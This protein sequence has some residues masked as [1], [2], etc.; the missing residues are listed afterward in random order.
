MRTMLL[1]SWFLL[2]LI[3]QTQAL[4]PDFGPWVRPTHGEPWPYPEHRRVNKAYYLL[5]ASTFQFNV[6][7]ETCDIVTDAVERYQAIILKEAKIAK[8]H[9]QGNGKSSS[10]NDTS[11][12]TLTAL[13]IHLGEPCEKDGNHWPHLQMSE[14]YVLSINEMSTAAKLV[15][16]SVWGILRGLETFSQLI[17][18]AGDGSNLKIKCQTIHDSPKLRHRG[19]LLDTSR[20]YLPISDILL[21]LD[22]MSYNKLNVLHW[23]IV[24]DNS[25]PYQSSKYPNLSAKG[26]YHPSMVYTLNDIQKIVDY[27]RLR[28]IRVMPEFD[29][30]GHTRSWGLAYPELLT[31]CYDAEG[32]TTGKLGPMN[33]INPNVYEFLR[34]L[35]AEI[36]QVF[37][38]QYVH[39]GGDEVPFSCWMSNPEIN[40]YMKHR[41]MSKN[42]ALL[43]GEYIAKLLQITDSLEANTIVWQE[44]FDNGVKMPNN[45]VVHVWTGNWAKELEGA[46]KA[47]HSVLLSACWYLDHV[48]GGGDWKKFYRCDPMAFAGASNATH[49]MLG[50][51]ACMWGEYV[52]K[53][54]VHS[55]IWPRASA[56]AERLWSTVKSDENIAAQRLEEHS[57]RMNRRGIPSQPPNGPG[58]CLT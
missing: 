20:H 19:L 37:P 31:T 58:F 24:D 12:G 14:S 41:N 45:T 5:R 11:K 55:R 57:C 18:P 9:S 56:A 26:A 54:N 28:G 34:H 30:P 46:T 50:G 52:D 13:N 53:N 2:A 40:D 17:S 10:G 29:T 48:A 44:V 27:A 33:P 16:D 25:F 32:K 22:A 7:G 1:G 23:H 51:E 3:I 36:V 42:Y 47:G 43:E 4:N 35:F 6:V 38:D 49:L 21:T 8:I 15:A 39:L